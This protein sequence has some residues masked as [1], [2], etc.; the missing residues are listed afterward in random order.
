MWIKTI[1]YEASEGD[2]RDQYDRQVRALGEPTEMTTAGSLHPPLVQARLDLYSATEQCPSR[3]TAH[4]RNLISYVTSALNR[5]GYCM[6][7]VTIKLRQTGFSDDQISSLATDPVGANLPPAD[8]ALVR[9]AAKLTSDPGSV[10]ENDIENLRS[11]GFADLEILDANAQCSH[12]NYVN[13]V[14][15]GLGIHSIVDPDFPAYDAI[16]AAAEGA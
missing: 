9:Y 2:L 15:M 11:A 7:Q 1:P 13:R 16:P 14:A 12:L 5:T 3:L 4:Q 10:S 8:A 6:S